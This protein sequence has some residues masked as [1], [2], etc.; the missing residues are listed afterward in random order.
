MESTAVQNRYPRPLSYGDTIAIVSPASIIDPLLIDGAKA[1]LEAEGYRVTVS[2]NALGRSGSYSATASRRLADIQKALTDPDVRAVLCSRGG[3]GCVHL[4]DKLSQTDLAADPKWL[5]GFSDV[6]VLHALMY[7]KGIVSIH[8]SMAK[9]LA[10]YDRDFGPNHALLRILQGKRDA[11]RIADPHRYNRPGV[12][13]GTL[14]GGNLAV[15]QALIGTPFDI[16]KPQTILFI[17][18]IAEP[19]YKI[20]RIL[21]Q[22][23]LSGIL[24]R[25]GGLIVGQFTDYRPDHNFRTM[26]DMIDN[27]LGDVDF[28]VS[29][30]AA[31]GHVEANLPILHGAAATL[32][33]DGN[34]SAISYT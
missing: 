31:I 24:D 16:F 27:T 29:F 22:L 20:E 13:S 19:V 23:R 17:E 21:Y 5:I 14:V 28:P 6:S 33:V 11:V 7:S 18:D 25:L 12:A 4:I 32:T 1:A 9:A 10:N 3:Y 8:G 15:L 34:G 30:G 2:P 26:E